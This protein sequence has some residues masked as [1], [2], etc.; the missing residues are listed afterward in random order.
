MSTNAV[1]LNLPDT[2]LARIRRTL[3]KQVEENIACLRTMLGE[4]PAGSSVRREIQGWLDATTRALEAPEET[5]I[6]PDG[7]APMAQWL[8]LR[9]ATRLVLAAAYDAAR[10]GGNPPPP[11]GEVIQDLRRLVV[12]DRKA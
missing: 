2:A 7:M 12:A 3:R 9:E 11:L 4:T 6:A 1:R 5:P 8:L 10:D